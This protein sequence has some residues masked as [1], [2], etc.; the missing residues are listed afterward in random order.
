MSSQ[1]SKSR[2]S[3]GFSSIFNK[4]VKRLQCIILSHVSFWYKL[5]FQHMLMELANMSISS[6]R[7]AAWC[8]VL[9]K[10]TLSCQHDSYNWSRD[11]SDD[12]RFIQ[13]SCLIIFISKFWNQPGSPKISPV[14]LIK[15]SDAARRV[16]KVFF[17]LLSRYYYLKYFIIISPKGEI[18]LL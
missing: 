8:L 1:Q 7:R 3:A 9:F 16:Y 14:E 13:M 5:L 6:G 4:C 18:R 11:T 2:L 12:P 17:K 10:W 15:L